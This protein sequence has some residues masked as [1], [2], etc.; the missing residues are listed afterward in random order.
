MNLGTIRDNNEKFEIDSQVLA[1]HAAMLGS[2]GSGKTVMAKT[3]IEEC[4]IDNIPSLIIDPQG[5][6]ARLCL[7]AK[8][9]DILDKNGDVSKA[10]IFREKADV[11]IWTPLRKKG[12]PICIDPFQIPTANLNQEESITAWDMV[13]AGFTA[14][15]DYDMEKPNGKQVRI[16][17]YEILIHM[18]RLGINVNNFLD[19]SRAAKSPDKILIEHMYSDDEEKPSWDEVC[20]KY[21]LPDLTS[22]LP[23]STYEELARRLAAYSSGINQL[24][25]S[26][27]VPID[28]DTLIKPSKNGKIPINIIYLNTIQD[29]A[30]KHYFVQEISRALYSWMLEQQSTDNKL[31]LLFFMDEVAPYLPPAPRNP[32]AKDLIKL[33]FKQA[34][35]YGV[36]SVLATQ[37]ASDVDYKIMAQAN[38]KFIGRFSQPQD[39]DKVKHLLKEDGGNLDMID[40]L[41]NLGPGQFQVVSPDVSKKAIPLQCRWLYT[42]HGAPLSEDQVEENTSKHLR[43]WAKD[44]S[45]ISNKKIDSHASAATAAGAALSAGSKGMAAAALGGES[46]GAFEV[47]L[48]GGLSVIR[49]GKDPLYVMQGISNALATIVLMWSM[50]VLGNQWK[51]GEL[52]VLWAL[53]GLVIT[54]SV[55]MI[56][57][58]ET[59]LNHDLEMQ[60]KISNFAR[61]NQYGLFLWLWTLLFWEYYYSDYTLGEKLAMVLEISVVWTSIFI[62]LEGLH[63]IRLGRFEIDLEGEGIVSK[64]KSGMESLTTVLTKSEMQK[65]EASSKEVMTGLRWLLDFCTFTIFG[66]MVWGKLFDKTLEDL[67]G[68]EGTPTLFKLALWLGS[69]YLL[70]FIAQTIVI[71]NTEN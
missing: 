7:N 2:T 12:L 70:I 4:T 6:L 41:P 29:E 62:I 68:G 1:R 45:A 33:I 46:D 32:P 38:T 48:M 19:L 67:F 3:L 57:G 66:V 71:K 55:F 58:L 51:N 54:F 64:L 8:E 25:F 63:R 22:M 9:K 34:R 60:Q 44:N 47:R 42:D 35:K 20:E 31:K 23:K 53:L 11:R 65:M 36:A 24:L 15:A 18:T 52:E 61:L 16:Y 56:I 40:E 69:I 13:A 30:Q 50:I 27:G 21:D 17:I 43:N 5:D 28:I 37:N 26:N 49:D 10:K 59:F 39:I 14:L